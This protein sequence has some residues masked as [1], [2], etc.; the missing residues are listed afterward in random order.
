MM[1][2]WTLETTF[3]KMNFKSTPFWLWM[4]LGIGFLL[5]IPGC[6]QTSSAPKPDPPLSLSFQ[7][8]EQSHYSPVSKSQFV[9]INSSESWS[10]LWSNYGQAPNLTD[11]DFDEHTVIAVFLGQRPT[12]GYEISIESMKDE[13]PEIVILVKESLPPPDAML[14]QALTAPFQIVR[15]AKI[16][17]PVRF[18]QH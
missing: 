4:F 18:I 17:K 8:I 12:G 10:D 11:V 14:T 13:G 1:M 7:V 6:A 3:W 15:T 5:P 9:V 2:I 16:T